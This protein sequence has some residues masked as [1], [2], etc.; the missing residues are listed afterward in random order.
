MTIDDLYNAAAQ[1]TGNAASQLQ[2]KLEMTD[3]LSR[4]DWIDYWHKLGCVRRFTVIFHPAL[5]YGN[6]YTDNLMNSLYPPDKVSALVDK[7]IQM[8]DM[9][10]AS[11]SDVRVGRDYINGELILDVMFTPGDKHSVL[12]FMI[13]VWRLFGAFSKDNY[14][15]QVTYYSIVP[16]DNLSVRL[17]DFRSTCA[18]LDAM[19]KNERDIS[20]KTNLDEKDIDRLVTNLLQTGFFADDQ[21]FEDIA[22]LVFEHM[23]KSL[24]IQAGSITRLKFTPE[25][26]S[27]QLEEIMKY[28]ALT[29]K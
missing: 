1:E 16:P 7:Y 12:R 25:W 9:T 11:H 21:T 24:N 22:R 4:E 20:V 17:S 13:D 3:G 28:K 26:T 2:Q 10:T 27:T 8:I 5:N 19:R 18:T 15:H 6:N 14:S 29:A 23:R